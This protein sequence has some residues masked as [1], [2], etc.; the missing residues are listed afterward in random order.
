MPCRRRR[1]FLSKASK[2]ITGTSS[3]CRSVWFMSWLKNIWNKAGWI[4]TLP[5]ILFVGFLI[6]FAVGVAG[7][8]IS[9]FFTKIPFLIWGNLLGFLMLGRFA[10]YLK[11]LGR[12]SGFGFGWHLARLAGGFQIFLAAAGIF[13][14]AWAVSS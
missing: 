7:S 4:L 9:L 13:L 3:A 2:A 12:T 14:I 8:F 10:F 5:L 6:L 1:R 11:K